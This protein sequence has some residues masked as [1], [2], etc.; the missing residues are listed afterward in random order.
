MGHWTQTYAYRTGIEKYMQG[1][2]AY[3]NV[4]MNLTIALVNQ[5]EVPHHIKRLTAQYFVFIIKFYLLHENATY[6]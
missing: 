2:P 6:L 3:S 4:P 5:L 1:S